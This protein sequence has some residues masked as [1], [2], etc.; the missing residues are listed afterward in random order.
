MKHSRPIFVALAALA[1]MG[2]AQAL[3][4]DSNSDIRCLLVSN[5]FSKSAKEAKAKELANSAKL[6]YAGRVSALSAAQMEAGFV[7]QEKAVTPQNA[8]A[9]MN[10]CAQAIDRAFKNIQTVGSKLQPAAAKK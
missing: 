2:P 4:Q 1:A 10:A 3:A 6:F 9:T 7:S 5:V 8:A